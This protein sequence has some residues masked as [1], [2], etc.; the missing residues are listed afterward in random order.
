MRRF[1]AP[2]KGLPFAVLTAQFI[3][4]A[5]CAGQSGNQ[6]P[7]AV[8]PASAHHV[9]HHSASVGVSVHPGTVLAKVSPLI[10][11]VGLDVGYN[12]TLPGIATSLSGAG[13]EAVRWP[14]GKAAM[15]YHWRANKMGPG[16][17]AGNVNPNS[18]FDNFMRDV[19]IPAHL[20]VAITVNY[21]SNAT[22]TGGA[23]PVEAVR[24]VAYANAKQNYGVKWWTVGNEP[25]TKDAL[26][27]HTQ[28][29]SPTQYAQIEASR[30]YRPMKAA[31]PQPINVCI[32]ASVKVPGW[33]SVVLTQALYDC[34]EL[35]FYPQT[36]KSISDTYL[37][38][39]AAPVLR[40]Q[41]QTLQS[42][43]A[44][45]GRSNTPIY[46][47]EIGSST[48]PLGKQSQSIVQALFAGQVIG[49]LLNAGIA[50]A[51]W[52]QGYGD[53]SL[54]SNGGDFSD[55]LY[56]WQNWGGAM[57]FADKPLNG[58]P[59]APYPPATTPLATARAYQVATHFAHAGESVLGTTVASL[60][61]IRA[62][63]TTDAGGYAVMLFNLNQTATEQ[64]GV[65][66]DGMASG[67]GG[68]ITTYDKSLYDQ[69]QNNVWAG[70]LTTSLSSWIGSFTVTLPPWSMTVVE[71]H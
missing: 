38:Q 24:W 9:H 67:H 4:V 32:P 50:R 54:P 64:V 6:L 27:L 61:D 8:T 43:L 40:S 3:L 55:A 20:D 30:F 60:P 68:T 71:T 12:I 31:S 49:E 2:L 62:Y 56:G 13:L 36:V 17:C 47:G 15:R 59:T 16:A 34:V 14:A 35:H 51:T 53:C 42:E 46:L 21:G 7:Q 37:L 23:N 48:S 39:Q 65:A 5:G 10:L 57:I 25:F 66:I 1:R 44:G 29:H 18:T 58:C 11:G 19:A 26:D 22:C 52:H 41:L 45:V 69:T 70:P 63:A 33:D 28:P